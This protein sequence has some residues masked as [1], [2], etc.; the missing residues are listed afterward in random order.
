MSTGGGCDLVLCGLLLSGSSPLGNLAFMTVNY[1]FFVF[2]MVITVDLNEVEC[3][4]TL[5]A[6]NHFSINYISYI[7]LHFLIV[8]T[9][10]HVT[11]IFPTILTDC[12]LYPITLTSA[13]SLQLLIELVVHTSG[14]TLI[15]APVSCFPHTRT[16]SISIMNLCK[17]LNGLQLGKC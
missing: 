14:L 3:S 17:I 7:D 10:V 12:L 6:K 8:V 16:P 1:Y 15:S 11:L 13:T 9:W 4:T 2:T 5:Q